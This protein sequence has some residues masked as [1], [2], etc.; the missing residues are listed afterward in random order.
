MATKKTKAGKL[1]R[2][3][4]G[5]RKVT[6]KGE[7]GKVRKRVVSSRGK[8]TKTKTKY[9]DGTKTKTVTNRRGVTKTVRKSVK[10]GTRKVTRNKKTR[11]GNLISKVR[12][13]VKS[14]VQKVKSKI[15]TALTSKKKKNQ[16]STVKLPNVK[17]PV[18]KNDKLSVPKKMEIPLPAFDH[19]RTKTKTKRKGKKKIMT[20]DEEVLVGGR[21]RDT[22][23]VREKTTKRRGGSTKKVETFLPGTGVKQVVRYKKDGTQKGKIKYK[24][25]KGWKKDKKSSKKYISG[26]WGDKGSLHKTTVYKR[27]KNNPKGKNKKKKK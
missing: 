18:Y 17:H 11:A 4:F 2:K 22:R 14:K 25:R 3:V 5:K 1:I 21:R 9:K 12:S 16:K 24:K 10:D 19:R 20:Y 15:K 27:K 26:A 13:K 7:D 6:G 8:R 23:R